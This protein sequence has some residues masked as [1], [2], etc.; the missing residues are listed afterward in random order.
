[1]KKLALTM[2]LA[3]MGLMNLSAQETIKTLYDGNPVEVTW[4]NTLKIEAENFESGVKVGD[5]IYITFSKTTD[6][7]ELKANGTW[8]PGTKFTSLGDNTPDLRTYITSDMLAKLKEYGME[9]CGASFTVS[10]VSICNDG[11]NMPDGAI[12][13]GYFWVENWNTLELFKTAFDNYAGQRYMEIYL[14]DDNGDNAD[15]F[16][17]VLTAWD[18]PNAVWADNG[19]ITH[20]TRKAIVD[21]KGIDVKSKLADVNTLMVQSNPEGG[22]PYNITAIVLRNEDGTTTGIES[23]GFDSVVEKADVYNLQGM[24][25]KKNASLAENLNELPAGIYITNGKKYIVK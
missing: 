22:S 4:D 11:F 7:I 17:K 5:Y 19:E 24:L 2:I 23:V 3:V 6:V 9:L 16:M 21:L 20:E 14:S 8:L 18:N 25:V 1:M 15:Y 10:E 13:G 12:W